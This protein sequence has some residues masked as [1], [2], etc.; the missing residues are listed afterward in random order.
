MKRQ[1]D[2]TV[3]RSG[4][5]NDSRYYRAC[6]DIVARMVRNARVGDDPEMLARAIVS[7]LAHDAGLQ[8]AA[9]QTEPESPR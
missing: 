3:G 2:W 8:P 4:R 1:R 6:V 9:P 7:H 5:S